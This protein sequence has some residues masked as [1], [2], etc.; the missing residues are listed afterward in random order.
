MPHST[1]IIVTTTTSE[2]HE[3]QDFLILAP[4]VPFHTPLHR[5]TAFTTSRFSRFL[6]CQWQLIIYSGHEFENF[7][8]GLNRAVLIDGVQKMLSKI[9]SNV[10]DCRNWNR[11]QL[12]GSQK[13]QSF[14]SIRFKF[15]MKI[16]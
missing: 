16:V 3:Y 1:V 12:A 15:F 2:H 14:E 13:I 4:I 11:S 9:F 5:T 6:V 8:F 10:F 7:F